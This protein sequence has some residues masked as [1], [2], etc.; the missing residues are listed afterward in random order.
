MSLSGALVRL[1]FV[2]PGDTP[3][4]YSLAGEYVGT[5]RWRYRSLPPYHEFERTIWDGVLAQYVIRM[6]DSNQ[7]IG[8]AVAYRTNLH[9]GYAYFAMVVSPDV[10]GTGVA[11]EAAAM[12]I[13]YLFAGWSFRKLYI[14]VLDS[15]YHSSYASGEG[16]YFHEEACLRAHEYWDG[17]Y[18]DTYLLA[19]YRSDPKLP[20]MIAR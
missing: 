17:E 16:R 11:M 13:D 4:L 10:A 7:A 14:E 9:S 5:L 20:R 8:M 3:Y 12:F 15:V 18:H 1:D 19:I 2:L 6:V